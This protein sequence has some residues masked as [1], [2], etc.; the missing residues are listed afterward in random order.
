MRSL[1]FFA[2]RSIYQHSLCCIPK[3]AWTS[4][5]RFSVEGTVEG[6]VELEHIYRS[7]SALESYLLSSLT[8]VYY[9]GSVKSRMAKFSRTSAAGPS[10]PSYDSSTPFPS[11]IM[12]RSILVTIAKV[13]RRALFT[14]WPLECITQDSLLPGAVSVQ[15]YCCLKEKHTDAASWR[16]V[17]LLQRLDKSWTLAKGRLSP[18]EYAG[19][20]FVDGRWVMIPDPS[21]KLSGT[22]PFVNGIFHIAA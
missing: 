14:L 19:K 12:V 10:A 8:Y 15:L 7:L 17:D 9:S 20:L 3:C 6:T 21:M 16:F 22:A 4:N 18:G 5:W 2:Y 13:S 11:T 1:R